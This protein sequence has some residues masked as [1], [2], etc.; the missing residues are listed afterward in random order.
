MTQDV[1]ALPRPNH[2]PFTLLLANEIRAEMARMGATQHDLTEVLGVSQ[3]AVSNRL[4]GKTPLD[5]NELDL[6]AEFFRKSAETL[7]HNAYR[8][9]R[10]QHSVPA[11]GDGDRDVK[12]TPPIRRWSADSHTL[13]QRH[14]TSAA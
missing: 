10:R 8:E 4:N 11:R 2:K 6:L 12:I 1:V 9:R 5:V 13:T 7:V 3:Q 14:L